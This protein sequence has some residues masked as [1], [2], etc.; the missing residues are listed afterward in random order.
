VGRANHSDL[1]N[2]I[3]AHQ[4]VGRTLFQCKVNAQDAALN[5]HVTGLPLQAVGIM[6]GFMRRSADSGARHTL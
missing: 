3:H 5:R 4:R 6:F 1:S 2:G